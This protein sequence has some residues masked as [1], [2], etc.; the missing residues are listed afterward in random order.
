MKLL[1]IS[2]FSQIQQSAVALASACHAARRGQRV[3]L[4]SVGPAH[5]L[6]A[7]VGQSL[8]ARPLELEPHLAAMEISTI[9]EVGKRWD[10]VR[11]TLRT[12][13]AARV[14]EIGPEEIPS[15]PGMDA[16]GGL[17]V[18]EKARQTG[19]FD[20]VVLD[21]PPHD[22]LIR[23]LSLPDVLRW[24]LR[25]VFGLD[26][27]PGRSRASQEGALIPATLLA[28]GMAAPLQELR[29]ELE[30]QRARF[31][32]GTGTRV[33]LVAAAEELAMP[34]V[35]SALSGLGLYGMATDEVV[36]LGERA[37]VSD[38]TRREFSPEVST[39]RPTLRFGQMA[40]APTTRDEWALRGAALYQDGE[41]F[42]PARS[43]RPASSEREAKLA[44]PFL[45]TKSLDIAL[46]SEE[47]VV[48]L[49]QL[50]RHVLLPGIASGGRLRAKVDPDEVLRLWVE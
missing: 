10:E 46:A 48:R 11:P 8:G 18:A 17:L 3:L 20:L 37:L 41:V 42:D 9:D 13:L 6:G 23:A 31:D 47:V 36:V 29:V 25:L 2:G 34:G 22:G 16:I 4:A 19:R 12:G 50:R 45:D 32:A 43:P 15:F 14:R 39:S 33:R 7:L 24:L 49:G 38:E 30:A 35:R 28:P 5:V 44:I 1:V 27:G 26:R 40:T 21:G